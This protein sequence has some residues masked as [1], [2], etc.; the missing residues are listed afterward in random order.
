MVIV[1]KCLELAYFLTLM[2]QLCLSAEF[3]FINSFKA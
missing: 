1:D 2:R 3:I